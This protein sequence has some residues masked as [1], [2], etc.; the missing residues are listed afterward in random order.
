MEQQET[1]EPVAALLERAGNSCGDECEG[2][3]RQAVALLEQACVHLPA[4]QG[5]PDP[6]ARL[7]RLGARPPRTKAGFY[8]ALL[9]VFSEF[10]DRHTHCRLPA[11][12]AD[13]VAF[14]PFV[15]REAVEDGER[16]L[17]VVA[18]LVD[19]L[20]RGDT[21]VSW[22]DLP[23]SEQVRRQMP[24]QHGANGEARR[25]KAVQTL[26][27]RPLALMPPPPE[28]DV[29][30]ECAGAEGRRRKVRLAWR[31]ARGPHLDLLAKSL[32]GAGEN[33]TGDCLRP[34]AVETS[35]GTFGCVRVA[36][37]REPP[38]AFLASFLRVLE[39]LP[40]EGLILDLRGCED[41][42]V[43]T[44][45]QLLQLFTGRKIEPQPFQFRVTELVLQLVRNCPALSEWR[46]AVEGAARDDLSHSGWRPLTSAERA[47][48]VGRKYGGPVV[49]VV[50]AL[51]YSS[52]EMLAA[53]F[54]DH[55]IGT[56]LGTAPQTGGGGASPWNQSTIFKLSEDE[57]FRPSPGAPTFRVAVRRCRR[58][59]GNAGK[60]VQGVGVTPDALHL[61][62]RNDLLN[63]DA[64]LYERAG[65]I[66]A[67]NLSRG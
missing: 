25:A 46:E 41:G 36:S 30:L 3:L 49:L 56:V 67:E 34:L 22:D 47:N 31:A 23:A 40:R 20:R 63:G 27:T 1:T 17:V 6:V 7:N 5:S 21:L 24:L 51:T 13:A 64:D 4:G 2:V 42:V 14:L 26:T 33:L 57:S 28:D 12:F 8:A 52:A 44:A 54:Q 61:P 19:D 45:E 16:R 29:L 62:T 38:D 53:G 48:G 35:H 60:P 32:T 65:K 15:A 55:G 50:D 9:S 39:S 37:L 58:V 18:S 43:P 59:R 66:L 11:P 10:G